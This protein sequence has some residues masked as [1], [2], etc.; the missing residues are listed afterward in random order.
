MLLRHASDPRPLVVEG[1]WRGR[2]L[3]APRGDGGFG[4]DPV[5]FDPESGLSAAELPAVCKN[6]VSH[7]GRALAA[8]RARLPERA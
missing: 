5:F 1:S 7:R 3:R 6:A 4:Y 2:I 8:L